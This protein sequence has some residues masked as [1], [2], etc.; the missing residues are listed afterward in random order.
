MIQLIALAI[1]IAGIYFIIKGFTESSASRDSYILHDRFEDRE[2]YRD[3]SEDKNEKGYGE[4]RN[5][6]K[7][8]KGGGVILIGPIPIVFGE[9]RYAVVALIL[10]IVLMLLSFFFMFGR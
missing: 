10:A 7:R 9:S 6:E 2:K 1:M 5:R 4:F 3:E 8:V